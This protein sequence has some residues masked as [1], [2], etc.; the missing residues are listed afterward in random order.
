MIRAILGWLSIPV[1]MSISSL[2][3]LLALLGTLIVALLGFYQWRKQNANP[4]RAA[5]ASAQRAAFERLWQMLE[6]INLQLRKREAGNPSLFKMLQDVNT[7]FL[8]NSLYF[9]DSDQLLINQY[10]IALNNLREKIYTNDDSEVSSAFQMTL[11]PILDTS[12][13]AIKDAADK[14]ER[15][16]KKIKS[17]IQR[18]AVSQ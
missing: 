7:F 15:L 4:N 2:A 10:V 12:D 5:N 17:K 11:V 6:E 14:V 1:D 16:R 9:E 3:P 8:T 18:I 13:K